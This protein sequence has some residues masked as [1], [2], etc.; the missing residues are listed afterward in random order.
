MSGRCRVFRDTRLARRQYFRNDII[1]LLNHSPSC[2]VLPVASSVD[3]PVPLLRFNDEH[4]AISAAILFPDE[5]LAAET[6]SYMA[7]SG[8][9]EPVPSIQSDLRSGNS[10]GCTAQLETE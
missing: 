5:R 1:P 7:A 4:S 3:G 8:K 10:V 6:V 2:T 9:I